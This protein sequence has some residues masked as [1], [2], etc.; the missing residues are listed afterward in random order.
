[1]KKKDDGEG[2]ECLLGLFRR[3]GLS[4]SIM[5]CGFQ[6]LAHHQ[7]IDLAGMSDGN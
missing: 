2:A 3:L 5:D 7:R 1:M 6:P 4:I